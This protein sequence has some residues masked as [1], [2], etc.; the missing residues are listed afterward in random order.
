MYA[1]GNRPDCAIVDEPFYACYLARTGIDHPGR[2]EILRS[3]STNPL[4]VQQ[5]VIMGEY[6]L[7][8]VFFKNMAH[9]VAHLDLS[10]L[11][12]LKQ[13]FLIRDTRKIIRSFSKVIEEPRLED[14]G[15]KE[16]WE[17]FNYLQRSGK[18]PVVLDTD[19]LLN[20]PPNILQKLCDALEI[21]FDSRMLEWE[22][23][24]RKEDGVWARYWYSNVHKSTG[25]RLQKT[26]TEPLPDHLEPLNAKAFPYYEKLRSKAIE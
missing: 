13:I 21:D 11:L 4:E 7:S 20:D 26:S 2:E 14:I 18:D 17:Q 22:P 12:D 10:L 9:H 1:F 24:P 8:M 23:G 5:E 19:V 6:D 15:I 25:F 16:E 3:Q